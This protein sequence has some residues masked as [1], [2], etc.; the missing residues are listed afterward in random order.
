MNLKM[1]FIWWDKFYN[2]E[3]LANFWEYLFV[4]KIST[5]VEV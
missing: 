3:G 2:R 5:L 4:T 1:Y